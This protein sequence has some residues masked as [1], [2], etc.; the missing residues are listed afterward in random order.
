MVDLGELRKELIVSYDTTKFPF[1]ELFHQMFQLG[2]GIELCSLHNMELPERAPISL[3]L[4]HGFT[5]AGYKCPKSWNKARSRKKERLKK[6]VASRAFQNFQST[7]NL[8]VNEVIVPLIGDAAGVVYQNPP[9]FR[10]QVPSKSP[11]GKPHRDAD[12]D[13]HV[14]TEINIWVPMTKVSQQF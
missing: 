10:V 1:R 6:F 2:E 11:M 5:V 7:F 8:F 9:T 4:M 14:D 13:C 12:Y 3:A